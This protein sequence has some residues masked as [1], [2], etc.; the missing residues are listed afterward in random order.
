M[1][2]DWVVDS[3]GVRVVVPVA[4]ELREFLR[5]EDAEEFLKKNPET[6][7]GKKLLDYD[8]IVAMEERHRAYVLSLCPK[9]MDKI[10]VWNIPDPYFMEKEEA[11]EIYEQLKE[12]V[13]KLANMQSQQ[14]T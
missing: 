7:D 4:E 3:A 14:K 5:K 8:V 11:W 6:L 1:K 9:C 10:I 2:P 12:K 13:A